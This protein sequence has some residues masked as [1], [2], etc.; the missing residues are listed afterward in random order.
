[1][2]NYSYIYEFRSRNFN[3]FTKVILIILLVLSVKH[4]AQIQRQ[5]KKLMCGYSAAYVNGFFTLGIK[6][7]GSLY[8]WIAEDSLL[9]Y[10]PILT[11]GLNN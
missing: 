7:I 11:S 3:L 8:G 6:Y 10:T 2:Y 9:N 1:M 5:K 4:Y